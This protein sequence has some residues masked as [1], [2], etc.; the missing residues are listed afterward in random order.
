M[1]LRQLLIS[2]LL[3]ALLFGAGTA[4]ARPA[5]PLMLPHANLGW[6]LMAFELGAWEEYLMQE[7][8][9]ELERLSADL[10]APVTW[11]QLDEALL[12]PDFALGL[13][14]T[15]SL[16]PRLTLASREIALQQL[17]DA[18][19][20]GEAQSLAR[21]VMMPGIT[22][23][24]TERSAVS[25]AAVL[26]TQRFVTAGMNLRLDDSG[27]DSLHGAAPD[28]QEEVSYGAG[29]RFA[30]TGEVV[31]GLT[32]EASYQSRIEM[33]EFALVRGV[34]GSQAALDIPSRLNVGMRLRT[35]ARGA[36]SLGMAQIFYS[37]V[38]AFP[39]RALPARFN[40]L[41]GDSTS[42]QFA[43]EDLTVYSIGWV[44]RNEHSV[45]FMLD[46]R[47][48]SQPRPSAPALATA[49]APE[50][51]Q[52]AWLVGLSRG[53]SDRS[54]LMINAAYAPPEFAF[55]GNV[56][57]VISDRLDQSFEVQATW[58]YEF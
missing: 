33:N 35:S 37:E 34:H 41:L 42:P 55:G 23:P 29:V 13:L 11:I 50:L 8:T 56:L 49:L 43:W 18:T 7:L 38:G 12:L 15:P 45:E 4:A 21:S 17:N 9:P 1:K 10:V 58:R 36:L 22:A 24:V 52:N 20:F 30:L 39:S 46:Y 40:A 19:G 16:R 51:A 32:L 54:R 26:A 6:F 14:Q 2:S 5:P 3:G 25:V 53:F 57:G 28:G 27:F 44:W 48:R 31:D 47:T